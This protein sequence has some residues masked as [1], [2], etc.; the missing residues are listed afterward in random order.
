MHLQSDLTNIALN[1]YH[2][3]ASWFCRNR[4]T[5]GGHSG[6]PSLSL[7]LLSLLFL[8]FLLFLLSQVTA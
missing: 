5:F 4:E 2:K 7:S 1:C 6:S 3:L 8:L